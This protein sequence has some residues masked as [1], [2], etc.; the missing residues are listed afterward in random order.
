[1]PFFVGI[2]FLGVDRFNPRVRVMSGKILVYA[3]APVINRNPFQSQKHPGLDNKSLEAPSHYSA[4]CSH[5][6]K[7]VSECGYGNTQKMGE[8]G[9]VT[10]LERQS[11]GGVG[12]R[13]GKTSQL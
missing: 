13:S 6:F 9:K 2:F 3:V 4:P 5:P 10:W 8:R 1:M 7:N 12:G 11:G